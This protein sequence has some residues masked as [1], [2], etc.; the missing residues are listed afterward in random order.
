MLI[1]TQSS[2]Q[3]AD[4][5]MELIEFLSLYA[6]N[7]DPTQQD[8]IK[9]S[10]RDI[11]WHCEKKIFDSLNIIRENVKINK[12]IRK[13]FDEII[14]FEMQRPESNTISNILGNNNIISLIPDK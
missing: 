14:Y 9:K 13:I 3:Y 2:S 8:N 5:T 1:I 10:I 12:D 6:E 7:F 11:F 4:L